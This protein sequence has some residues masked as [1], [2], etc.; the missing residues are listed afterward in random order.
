MKH[1]LNFLVEVNKLKEMRRTGWVLRKVRNPE[2]IAD[3][4]FR[5]A[6]VGWLL[7]KEKN[8]NTKKT[9]KIAFSHDLCEVYAGDVTPFFYYLNL[10]GEEKERKKILMKWVRLSKKEKAK[11]GKMKFEKERRG[12]LKLIKKIPLSFKKDILS[13]WLD[14]E[15]GLTK[16]GKFVK[17][18]DKIETLI[19]AIEYFGPGKTPTIGWWEEI[20]EL[21]DDPLLLDFLKVI[22]K[23]FYSG[24]H[25]KIFKQ[26]SSRILRTNKK[27]KDLECILDFLLEIGKLKRLHRLYWLLREVKN[28]ETVAGHIFTVA[29]MAWALGRETSLNQEKLLKM[30]LVHEISAVY[31]GDTTPYDRILPKDT[32]KRKEIFKKMVRLSKE[33]KEE[34]FFKDYE[35][36]KKTLEKLTSKLFPG[37][38]KEMIQLWK[39]YRTKSS[40][41]GYF[42][43]QVNI[44]AVL[45]Q[46]LLYE[47]QGNG[48]LA[49]PV[50]EWA[51]ETI[52]HPVCLHL[53]KEMKKKFYPVRSPV[54]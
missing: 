26:I 46:A 25:K 31:T 20:E 15:K 39:E 29:L 41:E 7:A 51:F 28:P 38:K 47:K 32:Q 34:I 36:E 23:K 21:I 22:Q 33:K 49:A 35:E 4:T 40:P 6:F 12:L 43:S 53:L 45:L 37:L 2:T 1:I 3:H 5:V 54:C 17:Q 16:E 11:R 44:L 50:W 48:L 9:I 10:P 18:V 8:L 42:L 52:D 13:S 27:E 24:I 19:Q 14:Y 30:A